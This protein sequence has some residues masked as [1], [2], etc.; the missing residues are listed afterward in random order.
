MRAP[1]ESLRP[2]TGAPI[3]R[4][5]S[6]TLQIL[7]AFVSERLPPKTVKSWA[8]TY[9]RRPSMRPKPEMTPSPGTFCSAMPKSRQWCSTSLSSSSKVPSSSSS[10][11]RSRAVSFPSR[12]PPASRGAPRWRGVSLPWGASPPRRSAPPPSSARRTRSRRSSRGGPGIAIPGGRPRRRRARPRTRPPGSRPRR[13]TRRSAGP[14]PPWPPRRPR[15]AS[16]RRGSR[17]R[18]RRP[19]PRSAAPASRN[20][21]RTRGRRTRRGARRAPAPAPRRALRLHLLPVLEEALQ[22]AVGERV[23]EKRVE[24]ARRHGADVGAHPGRLQDVHRVAQAGGEDLAVE[25]VVVED[26]D[27]VGDEL[28]ARGRDVV[29][30]ADEGRDVAGARPGREEGLAGA[31]NGGHVDVL[32]PP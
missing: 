18:G 20:G 25:V 26:L 19:P 5:R 13:R 10:S 8:K 4:A 2:T 31:A 15:A 24:D 9:T 22:A 30:A 29:E 17:R 11:T 1:P 3:F 23:L 6:M 32:C 27:D 28:H 16:R 21:P 7:R 12:P 14:G